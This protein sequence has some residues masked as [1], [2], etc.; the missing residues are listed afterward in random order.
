MHLLGGTTCADTRDGFAH[1]YCSLP[2]ALAHLSG[3]FREVAA[4]DVVIG[5]EEYLPNT[6]T[7]D[8]VMTCVLWNDDIDLSER[9]LS[10]GI[11]LFVKTIETLERIMPCLHE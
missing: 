5:L 2:E 8:D 9:G 11:I 1:E 7:R 4:L 3:E 10:H 6:V